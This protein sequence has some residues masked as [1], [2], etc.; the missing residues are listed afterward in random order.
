MPGA[1]GFSFQ[2]FVAA[3]DIEAR[4]ED[5]LNPDYLFTSEEGVY[6]LAV[7]HPFGG[8]VS[9]GVAAKGLFHLLDQAEAQGYGFDAGVLWEAGYGIRAGLRVR[10]VYTEKTWT[11]GL[12]ERFPGAVAGG[13]CWTYRPAPGHVVLATA[14][15]EKVFTGRDWMWRTGVEYA[16]ARILHLRLGLREGVPAGGG[17]VRLAGLWARSELVLDYALTLDPWD[18]VNQWFTFRIVF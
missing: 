4:H 18:A 13:A 17:G 16:L 1:L 3:T 5:S 11:T 14:D 12:R 7:A 8:G 9:A 10:D 15:A 6:T 2:R